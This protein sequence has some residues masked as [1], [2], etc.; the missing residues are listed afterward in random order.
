M[1]GS[2]LITGAGLPMIVLAVARPGWEAAGDGGETA[3]GGGGSGAGVSGRNAWAPTTTFAG[4]DVF[5]TSAVSFAPH[6]PQK[7]ALSSST[8]WHCAHFIGPCR[9]PKGSVS[10]YDAGRETI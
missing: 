4:C 2:L 3:L 7:R 10:I 5:S 8:V 9:I 1:K 6:T